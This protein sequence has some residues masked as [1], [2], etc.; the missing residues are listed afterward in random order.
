M[1]SGAK[2]ETRGWKLD[3]ALVSDLD[4]ADNF[5]VTTDAPAPEATGEQKMLVLLIDFADSGPRPFT[6]QEAND[7]IFNGDFQKFYKENS[8][9][10]VSFTGKVKDWYRLPGYDDFLIDCDIEDGDLAKVVGSD[11][12]N[13]YGRLLLVFNHNCGFAGGFSSLGKADYWIDGKY[14]NISK[15]SVFWLDYG[16]ENFNLETTEH[17]I[18][19]ALGVHHANS[20]DCG[21]QSFGGICVE[22]EYGNS[23]DIMGNGSDQFNAFYKEGLGWLDDVSV[24]EV[25]GSGNYVIDPLKNSVGQRFAKL[26]TL[27]E[28]VLYLEYRP[29]LGDNGSGLLINKT[30]KSTTFTTVRETAKLVDASPGG[31]ESYEE[32]LDLNASLIAPEG[33][34]INVIQAD[35]SKLT[36][37][38]DNNLPPGLTVTSQPGSTYWYDGEIVTMSWFTSFIPSSS[39]IT[40][41]LLP[42]GYLAGMPSEYLLLNTTPNDGSEEITV[43]GNIPAGQYYLELSTT[44]NGQRYVDKSDGVISLV[45]KPTIELLSPQ[46]GNYQYGETINVR[47]RSANL[48]SQTSVHI[49]VESESLPG[50][51]YLVGVGP[52]D[53]VENIQL[54]VGA[55]RYRLKLIAA[56]DNYYFP[57][58]TSDGIIT[59]DSVCT[60]RPPGPSFG[61]LVSGQ[62]GDIIRGFVARLTNNDSSA[63]GPSQLKPVFY[64][65]QVVP[66]KFI[67]DPL[68]AVTVAPGETKE[69]TFD[70][71]I[72]GSAT[73]GSYTLFLR[74]ENVNTGQVSTPPDRQWTIEVLPPSVTSNLRLTSPNGGQGFGR[75]G[76][77]NIGW[78]APAGLGRVV[79]L[80]Q[81]DSQIANQE[82][83][84]Y[85]TPLDAAAGTYTWTV[86]SNIE[87]ACDYRIKVA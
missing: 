70:A 22:K 53:G 7:L 87:P 78:T 71:Q 83:A 47:W 72:L 51:S 67:P 58:D 54:L 63:C 28:G 52:N 81:R 35:E 1:R 26:S 20:W 31:E 43:S 44:L 68:P 48:P 86:P 3:T 13:N 33:W 29:W 75:G 2:V 9:S 77:M 60:R 73:P 5:R 6:R 34:R 62:P 45:P 79:L 41:K 38:F 15:S 8:Y 39:L 40:M 25:T 57:E 59:I 80:L 49:Y 69:V 65:G 10:K 32:T 30:G 27:R 4:L 55:D 18:G 76:P 24:V 84:G 61:G 23:V 82:I 85:V 19:H 46:S 14:F 11:D 17:E 56:D 12:L 66:W 50:L 16:P 21:E 74:A 64:G 36:F 42:V 37:N